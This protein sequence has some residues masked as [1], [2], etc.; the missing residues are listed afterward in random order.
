MPSKCIHEGLVKAEIRHTNLTVLFYDARTAQA[1][2]EL[3]FSGRPEPEL[4]PLPGYRGP[5]H[6]LTPRPAR[7]LQA[8]AQIENRD[9]ADLRVFMQQVLDLIG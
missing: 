8:L 6:D 2:M 3:G 9:L 1:V 7:D 4:L 5:K